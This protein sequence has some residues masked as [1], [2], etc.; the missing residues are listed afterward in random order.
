MHSPQ[1]PK[2]TGVAYRCAGVLLMVMMVMTIMNVAV[3]F[4]III[5]IVIIIIMIVIIII[6]IVLI[7]NPTALPFEAS[8]YQQGHVICWQA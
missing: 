3:I 1:L 7:M 8:T 6:M 2:Y 4:I 5:M